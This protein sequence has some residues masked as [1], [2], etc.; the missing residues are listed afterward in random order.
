VNYIGHGLI[1]IKICD[2]F[3]RVGKDKNS[4]MQ[5]DLVLD[6]ADV[7]VVWYG[8]ATNT[9]HLLG[10]LQRHFGAFRQR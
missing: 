10:P 3:I 6:H 7:E 1:L 4:P 9:W 5:T 8:V 2:G